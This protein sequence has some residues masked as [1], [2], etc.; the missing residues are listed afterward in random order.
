MAPNAANVDRAPDEDGRLD[1]TK[2]ASE[3]EEAFEDDHKEEEP[4]E[5]EEDPH[6]GKNL[7]DAFS[8]IYEKVLNDPTSDSTLRKNLT[9]FMDGIVHAN[10]AQAKV[11]AAF[12]ATEQV[13]EK[14][15][16]SIL[17]AAVPLYEFLT[18]HMEKAELAILANFSES[19]K[20]R[21]SIL[22]K[23][24]EFNKTVH[25]SFEG[26]KKKLVCTGNETSDAMPTPGLS[27]IAEE[28]AEGNLPSRENEEDHAGEEF[29]SED[30]VTDLD[31][32]EIALV[33]PGMKE[34]IENFLTYRER[35][36]N[37]VERF[38]KAMDDNDEKLTKRQQHMLEIL[39]NTHRVIFEN[40]QES[41]ENLM[42]LFVENHIKRE[43]LEE[44]LARKASQQNKFFER[45]MQSVKGTSHS[46][47]TTPSAANENS[48]GPKIKRKKLSSIRKVFMRSKGKKR[49]ADS[50]DPPGDE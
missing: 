7:D 48:V 29:G 39:A 46:K 41:K 36:T 40:L 33:A 12:I 37:V 23:I 34:I 21:K 50:Q 8:E 13:L 47:P 10:Q 2:E 35:W 26:L 14:S 17:E 9:I 1:T 22:A 38:R 3:E 45:L 18:A 15:K 28:E 25:E 43:A 20:L 44:H 6:G 5:E 16:T 11:E 42:T 19:H 4:K 27:V 30:G 24:D 49:P 31:W 32:D